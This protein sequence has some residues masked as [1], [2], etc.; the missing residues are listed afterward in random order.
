[1]EFRVPEI[2]SIPT[3]NWALSVKAFCGLWQLA[4]ACVLLAESILSK[5]NFLPRATPSTVC[6]LL[7]GI[8]GLIINC[9]NKGG[10][11]RG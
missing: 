11:L 8:T 1:M 9:S 10:I 5:N 2:P 6:G 7:I 3:L 4:Q